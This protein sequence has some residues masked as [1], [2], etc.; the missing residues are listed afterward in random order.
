MNPL[1]VLILVAVMLPLYFLDRRREREIQAAFDLQN[2]I[3]DKFGTSSDVLAYLVSD[4][5]RSLAQAVGSGP[6]Q[7]YQRVLS[8]I[9]IGVIL[10]ASSGAIVLGRN[11]LK[12]T[13]DQQRAAFL[14]SVGLGFGFGF[15]LSAALTYVIAKAWGL[16]KVDSSQRGDQE[17][18]RSKE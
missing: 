16:L 13:A 15:L 14:G 2:R 17:G 18:L 9:Q 6:R 1:P 10:L 11:L 4:A 5:G 7:I 12:A 8:A 3:L